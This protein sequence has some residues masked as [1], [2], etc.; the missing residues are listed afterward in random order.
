MPISTELPL[1][2][3]SCDLVTPERPDLLRRFTETPHAVDLVL[4][5]RTIRL[6]TNSAAVLALAQKF[7]DRHQNGNA[8]PPEFTWRIICE[9]DPQVQT[10]DP[11]LFAFSDCGL[12]YVSV[13][14]RS[15]L[16]VDLEK[17]EAVSF[18]ADRFV[19]D[20][21]LL[22]NHRPLDL[23]FCMTAPSLGLTA[24]SG[25]CVGIEDRGVLVFGPPNSGKTTA[26]YV[27]A[28]SGMEF[29]ADQMI[30]LDMSSGVPRIW[31]DF[32]PAVFRPETL[33]FFPDLRRLIRS[34]SHDGLEFYYFDKAPLQP[35]SAHAV[36]P[37]CSLFLDRGAA[38]EP[39]LKQ[40]TGKEAL[41]RLNA[42]LLFKEDARFETQINTALDALAAQPAYSLQ[43]NEDP[44]TAAAIIQKLLR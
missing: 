34:S 3:S 25:G 12:R 28:Q 43:Y 26:C 16:A 36:H 20:E 32:F 24:L 44:K 22:R 39:R 27:A 42:C 21:S 40:M 5:D 9:S 37:V 15:F 23:L 35:G 8:G 6:Q 1:A 33:K 11:R 29:H 41:T 13:G 7:F 10:L 17:R 38:S 2:S 30:F 18:L 14:Q 4:M 31:G 19:E